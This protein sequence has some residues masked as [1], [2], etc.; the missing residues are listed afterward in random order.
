MNFRLPLKS[1]LVWLLLTV[2]P[3]PCA[4]TQPVAN[5]VDQAVAAAKQ[6]L[7]A[8]FTDSE[9]EVRIDI[10]E[11]DRRLTLKNCHHTPTTNTA[12]PL[13]RSGK[14]TVKVHC[15]QPAEWSI[16]LPATIQRHV[17]LWNSRQNIDRGALVEAEDI[18][19]NSHWLID[20]PAGAVELAEEIVGMVARQ[21]IQSG[22][23]IKYRQLEQPLAI[24]KGQRVTV[25][26]KEPGF[27]LATEVI[28]LENGTLG[29]T[30]K[31]RNAR[32]EKLLS[33]KVDTSGQLIIN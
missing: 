31:V 19:S 8:A 6:E 2:S 18:E 20:V 5:G 15:D 26:V 11:P 25:A 29:A 10:K 12:K 32:T 17:T 14:V 27:V 7:E 22:K 9:N 30:I 23:V 4:A 21:S 3:L 24:H 13:P 28:A 16:Y 1:P 33:A